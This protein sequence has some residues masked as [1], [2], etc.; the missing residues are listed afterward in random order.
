MTLLHRLARTFPQNSPDSHSMTNSAIH[1]ATGSL[2]TGCSQKNCQ[3]EH[4]PEAIPP[5]TAS[6]L[7]WWNNGI[8]LGKS[9][10]GQEPSVSL[11]VILFTGGV[12]CHFLSSRYPL[13][14][15]PPPDWDLET[16]HGQRPSS[17]LTSS[18][19]HCIGRYASYR[20]AS[21]LMNI[22]RTRTRIPTNTHAHS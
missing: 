5:L 17:L 3:L 13:D 18:G 20:N 10:N 21:L 6:G 15:D 4:P 19:S 7:E 9:W 14:G 12:W 2:V 11:S 1:E 16:P 8:V 22:F